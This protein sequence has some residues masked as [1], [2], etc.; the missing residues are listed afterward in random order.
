MFHPLWNDLVYALFQFESSFVVEIVLFLLSHLALHYLFGVEKK[1]ASLSHPFGG[2]LLVIRC[3]SIHIAELANWLGIR[4]G[5]RISIRIC[6]RVHK[7]NKPTIEIPHLKCVD[8]TQKRWKMTHSKGPRNLFANSQ[9]L[10]HSHMDSRNEFR[11]YISSETK[12][13]ESHPKKIKIK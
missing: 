2:S 12:R 5:M 1:N 8:E 11:I 3:F 4:I 13:R 7:Y 9:T 6:V 10:K